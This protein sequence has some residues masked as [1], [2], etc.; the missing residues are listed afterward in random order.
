M[1]DRWITVDEFARE[2]N[3]SKETIYSM[4]SRCFSSNKEEADKKYKKHGKTRLINA[5]YIQSEKEKV[6]EEFESLYFELLE[7]FGSEYS[8][9]K[10]LSSFVD[11]SPGTVNMYF[12]KQ[13]QVK[14]TIG[15]SRD[16]YIKAMKELKE[17]EK[18][19]IVIGGYDE[20]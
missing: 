20:I 14:Y 6:Q 1:C 16:L 12:R 11:K 8:F 19:H 9:A 10:A 17:Y 7:R 18:L 4:I 13:F 5:G 2:N 15:D 3:I